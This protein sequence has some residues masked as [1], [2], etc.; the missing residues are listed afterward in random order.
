MR[1]SE[2]SII[3]ESELVGV[4]WGRQRYVWSK[5]V[6]D[7]WKFMS[8]IRNEKSNWQSGVLPPDECVVLEFSEIQ[9]WMTRANPQCILSAKVYIEIDQSKYKQSK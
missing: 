3:Q 5:F 8:S 1:R 9:S 7:C 2:R 6:G 4:N